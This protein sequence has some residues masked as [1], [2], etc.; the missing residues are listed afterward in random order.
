MPS[1]NI[2]YKGVISSGDFQSPLAK[3][4]V[5]FGG[6]SPPKFFYCDSFSEF[7]GLASKVL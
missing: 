6:L 1:L 4:Y 5:R 2:V 3:I 7:T